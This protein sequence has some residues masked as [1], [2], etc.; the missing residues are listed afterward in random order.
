MFNRI[1]TFL[2]GVLCALV[3]LAGL[4]GF[5]F[6]GDFAIQLSVDPGPLWPSLHARVDGRV[7]QP[8]SYVKQE[9]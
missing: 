1:T 4:C 6:L 2:S 5:G 7:L 9:G 3:V 8:I